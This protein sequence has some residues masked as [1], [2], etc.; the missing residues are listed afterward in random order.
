MTS[1]VAHNTVTAA[2]TG[3]SRNTVAVIGGGCSGA[4]TAAA[5]ARNPA[6]RT[7]LISPEDRPGRGV[8]YGAAEPWHLL[9]SRV[10]AMSADAGDPQH[11]LRWCRSRGLPADAATF[12]PRAWYG[13]YLS[14]HLASAASAAGS[15][16][17]HHKAKAVEVR[18]E[19]SGYTI[20]DANGCH[21]HADQVILALGNPPPRP[22]AAVSEAT[23]RS[24]AFVADPWAPGALTRALAAARAAAPAPGRAVAL[25]GSAASALAGST[26]VVAAPVVAAPVVAAPVASASVG[27]GDDTAPILLLGTG[28]TAI[29]V[30]L[31][32]NEQAR[33]VPMEALSRRGLLPRTHP[34]RPA[35]AVDLALPESADLAPLLRRVRAAIAEGADGTAVVEYVRHNADRLW[36]GLTPA[37]QERFLRHVQR[38]WEVHRHRMAPPVAARI[39]RLRD[40]GT[41]RIR[42]GRLLSIDPDPHGG[43]TVRIEGE[44]PR[45]YAAVISCTGPG[46]LPSSA[47][48]LLTGLLAD[49]LVKTGPHGLGL[50]S[51]PD[52][53]IRPG[54]WLI[55]PLRRGRSWEATAVPEI[56]TQ[57]ERLL[58]AL[59][60]PAPAL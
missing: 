56:R 42:S 50:D 32:I 9:N 35:P 28:L 40:Q 37:A 13:D 33:G 17:V 20:T 34:Q 14:G 29:D 4:L 5:I 54:L 26:P 47:G 60:Q 27:A 12:L 46:P 8:A 43:L 1:V 7:V 30:V 25:S 36:N 51:D 23:L 31:T 55:G 18:P 57:V 44:A 39:T 45:R 6:W 49:G 19:Q 48:P 22:P 21:I 24:P 11:L 59:P 53:Q 41:L 2:A 10:G 58:A 52:G 16:L 3:R 38:Y 15:R